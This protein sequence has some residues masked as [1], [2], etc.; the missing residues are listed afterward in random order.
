MNWK[1]SLLAVGVVLLASCISERREA[2][3]DR[4]GEPSAA[5]CG[6]ALEN[7]LVGPGTFPLGTAYPRVFDI[8]AG[9]EVRVRLVH[10]VP[11]TIPGRSELARYGLAHP[12]H[13]DIHGYRH[14]PPRTRPILGLN[15]LVIE[16]VATGSELRINTLRAEEIDRTVIRDRTII[17]DYDTDQG[18][19][20]LRFGNLYVDKSKFD[21]SARFPTDRFWPLPPADAVLARK[22]VDALFDQILASI[23]KADP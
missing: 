16:D 6:D 2:P 4:C 7:V 23:R 11:I 12:T 21:T 14:M 9:G 13:V 5:G 20:L 8:P 15:R 10:D 1:L 22:P 3:A 17:L 18:V 19:R